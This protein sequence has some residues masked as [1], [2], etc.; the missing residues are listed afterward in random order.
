MKKII[1]LLL[2]LISV[3]GVF[4]LTACEGDPN[5]E[6]DWKEIVELNSKVCSKC[7]AFD[8]IEVDEEKWELSI[9][10][11]AFDNVT[12]S[13]TF[14]HADL[15]VE[16]LDDAM[17]PDQII[18]NLT[19]NQPAKQ[20]QILKIADGKVYRKITG[21]DKDGKEMFT[22]DETFEGEDATLQRKLFTDM[23]IAA[24]EDYSKYTF[25]AETA[26]YVNAGPITTS[27]E[28]HVTETMT[29]LKVKFDSEARLA[30]FANHHVESID[31]GKI[32]SDVPVVSG[33]YKINIIGDIV[34]TYSDY[35]TTVID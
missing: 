8:G 15:T 6:H 35:G 5:C 34:W 7:G 22:F 19:E 29:D 1:A 16:G 27:S 31:Y 14:T 11:S 10:E 17:N 18:G 12:I 23:F 2:C 4:T 13:F 21:I 32:N 9:D 25:D 28:E 30:Y 24:I 26:L 20:I 3:L 33:T